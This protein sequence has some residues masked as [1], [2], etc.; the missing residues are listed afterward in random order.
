[1]ETYISFFAQKF[2]RICQKFSVH[3]DANNCMLDHHNTFEI[4]SL[5]EC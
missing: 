1:M 5:T 2:V 4:L 3:G